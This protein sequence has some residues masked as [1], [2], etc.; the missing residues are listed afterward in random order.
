MFDFECV[1]C[2]LIFIFF[3][4]LNFRLSKTC[5]DKKKLEIQKNYI[6]HANISITQKLF[7]IYIIFYFKKNCVFK[8]LFYL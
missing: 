4:L 8:I 3:F 5:I 1:F 2:K 7:L 6:L